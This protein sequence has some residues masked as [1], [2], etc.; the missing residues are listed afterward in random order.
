MT[1]NLKLRGYFLLPLTVR[2][3]DGIWESI[4][5][6]VSS[7]KKSRKFKVDPAEDFANRAYQLLDKIKVVFIN[8]TE[9]IMSSYLIPQIKDI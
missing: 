1:I 7:A 2:A 4:K 3:V 9:P 6:T 8:K 5:R